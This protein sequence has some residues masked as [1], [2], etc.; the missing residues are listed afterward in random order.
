MYN[1]LTTLLMIF[2]YVTI[3]FVIV[4]KRNKVPEII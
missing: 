1:I 2:I 4:S 3:L